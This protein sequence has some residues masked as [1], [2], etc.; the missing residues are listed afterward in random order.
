M[1]GLPEEEYITEFVTGG[2]RC[3]AYRTLHCKTQVKCKGVTLNDK[4]GPQ[5]ATH[6]SLAV[7]VH[8]FVANQKTDA[9]M[10]TV[11]ETIKR[12]KKKLQSEK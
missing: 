8:S 3:Y 9:C 10:M 5:D 6:E 12:D 7:L 1:C 4:K 11:S 2:L